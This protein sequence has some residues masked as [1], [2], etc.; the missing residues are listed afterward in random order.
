[1]LADLLK[2]KERLEKDGVVDDIKYYQGDKELAINED[3]FIY[4]QKTG[5]SDLY[6]IA[7]T[8]DRKKNCYLMETNYAEEDFLDRYDNQEDYVRRVINEMNKE[9][10]VSNC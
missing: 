4:D 1:M 2:V 10:K 7:I 6:Y 5:E 9:L 3:Y 8:V